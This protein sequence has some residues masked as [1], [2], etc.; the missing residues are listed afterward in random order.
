MLYTSTRDNTLELSFE[1]VVFEGLSK[2]GGLFIPKS[3][4]HVDI[5]TINS[6]KDLHFYQLAAKIMSYYISCE[7]IPP[8]ELMNLC[9]K[10][11]V[12]TFSH[13]NTTPVVHYEN[14]N[15][16][17]LYVLELFHGPTF[18]FKDVAL[19]F[20]GN[21]F[22]YFLQRKQQNTQVSKRITVLGA[23]SGD[24]GGAAIYGLRG[25]K[26]VDVFI[27]YPDGRVAPIQERQMISILDENVHCINLE[28]N[29]DDCQNIVKDCFSDS[30]FRNKFNLAA[31]NSIN[32]ARI[33]AQ[34]VYY[35]HSYFQWRKLKHME[36]T[37]HTVSYSVP[38][39]NFGDILAGY[40]AKQMG[41]PIDILHVATNINDVLH[42]FIQTNDL[43]NK[44]VTPSRAPAMDISI[45]SNFERYLYYLSGCDSKILRG[46]MEAFKTV[47]KVDIP[48][49]LHQRAL[50]DFSSGCTSDE[51]ISNVIK[52][53]YQEYRYVVCPHTAC[54]IDSLPKEFVNRQKDIICLATA[55]PGKFVEAVR[56]AI[57]RDPDFPPAL[58]ALNDEN[59]P[60]K[61]LRCKNDMRL[62]Q[63]LVTEHVLKK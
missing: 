4:P 18:A 35:F 47:G 40:Y 13:C 57:G 32:W 25:K 41:L 10:S 9:E 19:Q 39:G 60:T 34:I 52:K 2:E 30:E 5:V 11:Y 23:T 63:A 7:E 1:D 20:L 61:V 24:T 58:A 53:C 56:D 48:T 46:W 49:E 12:K 27:L 8:L 6:W 44:G 29:F 55:H 3:I 33:L 31:I 54:G 28:G 26:N 50:N 51:E 59:L 62:I 17:N 45:S 16:L 43:S 15:Y 42:R 36:D 21:L 38:T 22:E 14:E 37:A